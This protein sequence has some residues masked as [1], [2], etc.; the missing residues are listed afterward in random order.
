M[1][2]GVAVVV[3]DMGRVMTWREDVGLGVQQGSEFGS[4][5]YEAVTGPV[6]YHCGTAFDVSHLPFGKRESENERM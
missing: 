1:A 2:V 3:V 5:G 4:A 6:R